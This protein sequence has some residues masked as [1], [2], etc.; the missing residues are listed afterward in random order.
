LVENFIK[1][2]F[3]TSGRPPDFF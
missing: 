2:F 3:K 1:V